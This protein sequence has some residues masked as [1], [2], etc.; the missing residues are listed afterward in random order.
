MTISF[1]YHNPIWMWGGL[2]ILAVA[3]VV[4][5]VLIFIHKVV[6]SHPSMQSAPAWNTSIISVIS[7]SYSMLI[8]LLVFSVLNSYLDVNK[9]VQAEA[10]LVGD[11]YRDAEGLPDNVKQNVRTHLVNYLNDVIDREWPVQEY[12]SL[13][14]EKEAGWNELN[15]INIIIAAYNAP[16]S[17]AAVIQSEIFTRINNLYDMRRARVFASQKAVPS[18]IWGIIVTGAAVFLLCLSLLTVENFRIKLTLTVLAFTSITLVIMLIIALDRPF[19]GQL[20]IGAK[21]FEIVRH[22]VTQLHH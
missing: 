2:L 9:N 19:Q 7:T 6:L 11:L 10:A 14:T 3:V 4:S 17:S 22:N 5:L 12:G 16:T 20:G 18:V 13:E 1:F 8:A 21:E 15:A